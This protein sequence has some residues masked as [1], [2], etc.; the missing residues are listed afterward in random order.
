[1]KKLAGL[2][3]K[4]YSTRFQQELGGTDKTSNRTGFLSKVYTFTW[5]WLMM[6]AWELPYMAYMFTNNA[7]PTTFL[8]LIVFVLMPQ[9]AIAHLC[10]SSFI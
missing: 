1:M 10:Y 9:I 2:P 7:L 3:A 5:L 4:F 6:H 8:V